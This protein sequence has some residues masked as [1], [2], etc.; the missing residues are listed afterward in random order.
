MLSKTGRY[1]IRALLYLAANSSEGHL[2][3]VKDLAQ[4]TEISE[5]MLS[6]VLQFL[7]RQGLITSKKGRR[8]GFYLTP[9]QKNLNLAQV[10][11]ALEQTEYLISVCLLGQKHCNSRMQCPYQDRVARI[12]MEL[13]AIYASDTVEQTAQKIMDSYSLHKKI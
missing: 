5:H 3:G 4:Q 7:T 8:G 13:S 10:I 9:E 12:R 11:K 2:I 6:K 1:G